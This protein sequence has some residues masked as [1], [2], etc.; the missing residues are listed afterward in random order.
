MPCYDP[1]PDAATIAMWQKEAI[2]RGDFRH[3][4]KLQEGAFEELLCDAM[5]L[6]T[7]EQLNTMPAIARGWWRQHLKKEGDSSVR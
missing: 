3:A 2:A 7:L 6:M 5:R 4:L 1:P